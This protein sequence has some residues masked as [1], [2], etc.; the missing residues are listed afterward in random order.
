MGERQ[1]LRKKIAGQQGVVDA[2]R[3][4]IQE[5]MKKPRP[6]LRAIEKWLKDI[7]KAEELIRRLERRLER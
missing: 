2:H 4:K 5:E 3:R 6:N 1:K 7:Q